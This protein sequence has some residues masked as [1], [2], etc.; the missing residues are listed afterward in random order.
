MEVCSLY[1]AAP[2]LTAPCSITPAD[3]MKLLLDIFETDLLSKKCWIII[4]L[5]CRRLATGELTQ[6]ITYPVSSIKKIQ[7]VFHQLNDFNVKLQQ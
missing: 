3:C 2:H 5:P 4:V 7:L 1:P 6:Q